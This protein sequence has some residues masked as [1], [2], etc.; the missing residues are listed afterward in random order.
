MNIY[1]YMYIMHLGIYQ[2]LNWIT[3]RERGRERERERLYTCIYRLSISD[4][5]C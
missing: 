5:N 1:V 4:P 3:Y 2:L